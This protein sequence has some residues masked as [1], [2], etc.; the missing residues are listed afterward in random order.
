MKWRRHIRHSLH[1]WWLWMA[2]QLLT[3]LLLRRT[4]DA[5]TTGLPVPPVDG[6]T[7]THITCQAASCA[8]HLLAPPHHPPRRSMPRLSSVN[9]HACVVPWFAFIACTINTPHSVPIVPCSDS[10]RINV[11]SS[12]RR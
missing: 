11:G 10:R 1:V 2:R 12:S 3:L 8:V 6:V 4:V 7:A 9:V 5:P